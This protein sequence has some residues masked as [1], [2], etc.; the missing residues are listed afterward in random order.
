MKRSRSRS[1]SPLGHCPDRAAAI[2][3]RHRIHQKYPS[4]FFF[5]I[6]AVSSVSMRRPCRSETRA[7]SISATMSAIEA[8]SDSM[9]PDQRIASQGAEADPAHLGDLSYL[10][11]QPLV[12]HHDQGAA[13]HDDRTLLGEIKRHDRNVLPSDIAPY[14]ELGPIGQRKH[15]N[16]FAGI[17]ARVE[18]VP[19]FRPLVAR[20]PGVA[21]GA[22][23]ED[24]FLGPALL[25]VAPRA[26]ECGIEPVLVQRLLER[27]GLHDVGVQGRAGGDRIDAALHAVL[28]D[29]DDQIEREPAGGLVAKRNHLAKFPGGV[30][31]QQRERKWRGIEG[32]DGKVQ[33]DAGV[34]A[35]RVEHHRILEFGD[36]LAHD[37][38]RLRLEP[39]EVCRK[40]LRRRGIGREM[41]CG[42]MAREAVRHCVCSSSAASKHQ[43]NRLAVADAGPIVAH[44]S[45]DGAQQNPGNV[46]PA[47]R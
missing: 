40:S 18:Q 13:A 20:V 3:V 36:D 35:D 8:A 32:L 2:D 47:T 38:D 31:V 29:M 12:V 43:L 19:Q 5:S 46:R 9:A 33:H 30:D 17:D 27:L 44:C 23:R 15:P 16:R 42:R 14:V 39:L 11:R 1:G 41:A 22:K 26:A 7:V 10:Q 45:P 6:E 4:R 24:A 25:L 34:L 21:L 28:V 37:F